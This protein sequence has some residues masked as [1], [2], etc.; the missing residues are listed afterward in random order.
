MQVSY[1]YNSTLNQLSDFIWKQKSQL[2]F[3]YTEAVWRLT[4]KA[5]S[6]ACK[7]ANQNMFDI[8]T[9]WLQLFPFSRF[10]AKL[11]SGFLISLVYFICIV[12]SAYAYYEYVLKYFIP[13]TYA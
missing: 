13:S 3:V 5:N 6:H 9:K 4:M 2:M 8:L 11:N 10:S 12:I 1:N 7:N